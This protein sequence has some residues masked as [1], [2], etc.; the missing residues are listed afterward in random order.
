MDDVTKTTLTP[1]I[2]ASLIMVS[3]IEFRRLA[4]DGWFSSVGRNAYRLIDVVQGRLRQLRKGDSGRRLGTAADAARVCDISER[5]FR[6]MLDAGVFERKG[7]GH[8]DLDEVT[9][10]MIRHQRRAASGRGD[11][12]DLSAERAALA[13]QQRKAM[14]RKNA[15]SDGAFVAV[16]T[17]IKL[18]ESEYGVVREGMLAVPGTHSDALADAARNAASLQDA[19]STIEV[20]LRDAIHEALGGLSDAEKIAARTVEMGQRR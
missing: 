8:Y 9:I 16:D 4:K 19:T 13:R 20:M 17:V 18:V 12:L 11:G 6:E 14:E 3:P 2:G 10:T 1:A 15:I 7:V 5:R